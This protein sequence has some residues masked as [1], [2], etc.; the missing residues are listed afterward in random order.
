M[1]TQVRSPRS[2][3]SCIVDARILAHLVDE[4]QPRRVLSMRRYAIL[5]A[6]VSLLAS[7]HCVLPRH[8]HLK[9]LSITSRML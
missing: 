8:E 3:Q 7:C 9:L 6:L 5:F 4:L 2:A 1:T